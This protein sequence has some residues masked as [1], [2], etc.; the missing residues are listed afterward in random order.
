MVSPVT[1]DAVHTGQASGSSR[2]ELRQFTNGPTFGRAVQDAIDLGRPAAAAFYKLTHEFVHGGPASHNVRSMRT[3]DGVLIL[4][5]SDPDDADFA[6]VGVFSARSALCAFQAAA[7]MFGWSV[8][9][10]IDG[11]QERLAELQRW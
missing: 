8:P 5:S 11:L 10:E 7:S 3:D 1:A 2:L 9:P 4:V 6:G